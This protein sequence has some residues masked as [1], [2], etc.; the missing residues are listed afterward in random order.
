VV[1]VDALTHAGSLTNVA[2]IEDNPR[3]AFEYADICDAEAMAAIFA[4]HQPD[5]VLHMAEAQADRFAAGPL[6][7][8]HTNVTGTAVLLETVRAYVD[9]L[10]DMRRDRFRLV[11]VSSDQVF[12]TL[13]REGL[14]DENSPF[15]PGSP[16]SASK[17]G[18]DM[19]VRAWGE[20][21]GLPVT[22]TYA[23]SNYGPFQHPDKLIPT[24]ILNGL[25]GRAIPVH[26]RGLQ[27]RDWLYV[28]DHAAALL[29]VMTRGLAGETYCIGGGDERTN[30]DV[31]GLV[32]KALDKAN[33]RT[34]AHAELIKFVEDRPGHDQRHAV[35]NAK[36]T[37]SLR[38]KPQ[39]DLESG[40][41]RTVR[42]YIDNEERVR[43]RAEH[44]Q[45]IS[46]RRRSAA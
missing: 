24:V 11:H 3:Y 38:W 28:D 1:N 16:Y 5:W 31:V 43:A 34:W 32:C 21:Y 15:Q 10:P 27:V 8:V 36:I 4:R 23:S 39:V 44:G 6:G 12:G 40:I 22:V 2:D 29:E 19:L 20:A 41:L 26:G 35:S 37:A 30:L 46:A 18:A 13:G 33:P 14:W 42:W 17:A 9:E 25:V 45:R 7:F